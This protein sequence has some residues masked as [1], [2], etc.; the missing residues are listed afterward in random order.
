MVVVMMMKIMMIMATTAIRNP[1]IRDTA[2]CHRQRSYSNRGAL[3]SGLRN[4]VTATRRGREL[5]VRAARVA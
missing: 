4:C 2:R 3:H 1:A 5:L